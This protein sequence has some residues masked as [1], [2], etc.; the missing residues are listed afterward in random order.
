MKEKIIFQLPRGN[1]ETIYSKILVLKKFKHLMLESSQYKEAFELL[2]QHKLEMNLIFDI[3]PRFFLKNCEEIITKIEKND[4]LNLFL[5]SVT[6]E[7]SENLAYILKA[8]EIKDIKEFI[9]S[10][11]AA[12]KNW[13]V[14]LIC[15]ETKKALEKTNKD[16]YV[17]SIMTSYLKKIPSEIEKCLDIIREKKEAEKGLEL[18]QHTPPHLNPESNFY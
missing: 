3:N 6:N 10:Q 14:N 5:S 2:R 15:E 8:E 18:K 12:N 4:Y 1:L 7:I 9:V 11:S 17:L 16:R 13:K